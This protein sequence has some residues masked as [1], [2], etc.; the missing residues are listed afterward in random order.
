MQRLGKHALVAAISGL[1]LLG[2]AGPSLAVPSGTGFA[3][4]DDVPVGAVTGDEPTAQLV[5]PRLDVVPAPPVSPSVLW[6]T[7]GGFGVLVAGAVAGRRP[8]PRR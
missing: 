7:A 5:E 2:T 1:L 3:Q 6:W 8:S 4:I